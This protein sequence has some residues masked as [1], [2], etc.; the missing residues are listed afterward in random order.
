MAS[1]PQGPPAG[2]SPAA[3][4]IELTAERNRRL[5][6]WVALISPLSARHPVAS[7]FRLLHEHSLNKGS[8]AQIKA[9]IGLTSQWHVQIPIPST[10]TLERGDRERS[11]PTVCDISQVR[12]DIE[13]L[14]SIKGGG[15]SAKHPATGST[16]TGKLESRYSW[17]MSL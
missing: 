5:K 1:A 7:P 3:I 17:P 13:T 11:V 15:G 16:R 4:G 14:S 9:T 12:G 6:L 2:T 10:A 8:V